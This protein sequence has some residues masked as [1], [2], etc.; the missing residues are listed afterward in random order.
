MREDV[1]N[2][3]VLGEFLH[4]SSIYFRKRNNRSGKDDVPVMDCLTT[5]E[6]YKNSTIHMSRGKREAGRYRYIKR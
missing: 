4:Y 5:N 6:Q 3:T 1:V 2:I